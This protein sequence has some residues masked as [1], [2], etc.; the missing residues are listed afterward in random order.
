MKTGT[1]WVWRVATITSPLFE[2]NLPTSY[3]IPPIFRRVSEGFLD[4]P[5]NLSN[6]NHHPVSI[7]P[8]RRVF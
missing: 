2:E 6:W 8:S 3:D 4:W 1:A 7:T 5:I